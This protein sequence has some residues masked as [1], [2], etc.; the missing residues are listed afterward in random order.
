VPQNK[1]DEDNHLKEKEQAIKSLAQVM[2]RQLQE[3]EKLERQLKQ[4]KKMDEKAILE[5]RNVE[6]SHFNEILQVKYDQFDDTWKFKYLKKL[7]IRDFSAGF[8]KGTLHFSISMPSEGINENG[9]PNIANCVLCCHWSES[10]APGEVKLKTIEIKTEI[11]HYVI[12]TYNNFSINMMPFDRKQFELLE[13][14]SA[15]QLDGLEEKAGEAVNNKVD[16]LSIGDIKIR[17]NTTWGSHTLSDESVTKVKNYWKKFIDDTN[18]DVRVAP[19]IE[20]EEKA[21]KEAKQQLERE[22]IHRQ[23]LEREETRRQ[24]RARGLIEW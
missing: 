20:K 12:K 18:L 11:K 23:T 21:K 24:M 14:S 22:E 7:E 10:N 5:K 15:E 4:K 6:R 17:I 8:S 1:I 2:A 9:K 3:K 19:I 16:I 13:S